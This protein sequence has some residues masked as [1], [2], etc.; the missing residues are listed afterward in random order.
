MKQV[1]A[2]ILFTEAC[3]EYILQEQADFLSLSLSNTSVNITYHGISDT[4]VRDSEVLSLSLSHCPGFLLKVS[5]II[6]HS[7]LGVKG[8][9]AVSMQS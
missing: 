3:A 8:T 9:I 5:D 6:D 1:S 7:L 2:P 4:L